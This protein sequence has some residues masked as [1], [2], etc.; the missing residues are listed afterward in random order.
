MRWGVA[1]L[2]AVFGG[3]WLGLSPSEALACSP[4]L[5]VPEPG[6]S[7]SMLI[8][9]TP[10]RILD[11]TI[12]EVRR[13][14]ESPT[15]SCADIGWVILDVVAEDDRTARENLRYLLQERYEGEWYWLY[16]EPVPWM[17]ITWVDRDPTGPLDLRYRVFVLDQAGNQSE[18]FEVS[19]SE[20]LGEGCNLAR[21][22]GGA[23]AWG[24]LL[25]ALAAA[26]R[27]RPR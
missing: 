11:A 13:G 17:N 27:R 26:A 7:V 21:Q 1:G 25:A 16:G 10:P 12:S 15:D 9:P 22:T 19:Y 6:A 5:P 4:S 18:P 20:G 8:D 2:V 24:L 23:P 3:C 14:Y